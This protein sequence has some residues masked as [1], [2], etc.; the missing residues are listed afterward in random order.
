MESRTFRD[1][2]AARGCHFDSHDQSGRSHGHPM[3][4]VHRG[5]LSAKLPLLGLHENLDPRVVRQICDELQL[6]WSELPGPQ[7]RT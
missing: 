1:W 4:T 3:V 2:L 5:N 7:S 6:D